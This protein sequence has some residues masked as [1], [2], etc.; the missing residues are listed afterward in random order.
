M[1]KKLIRQMLAAQILSAL[2]VSLCLLMLCPESVR[3]YVI[4]HELCHR[5][6]MNHSPRF[7]AEVEKQLPDYRQQRKWL[8]DNGAALLDRLR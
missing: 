8:K 4:V 3:E 5:L 1:I 7:W 6:E 2:T